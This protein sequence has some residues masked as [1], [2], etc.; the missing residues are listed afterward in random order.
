MKKIL[1]LT[2][3]LATLFSITVVMPSIQVAHGFSQAFQLVPEA[4]QGISS[5][6]LQVGDRVEGSFSLSNLGPYRDLLHNGQLASYWIN[7]WFLDPEGNVIMNFTH[8]SGDSFNYTALNWGTYEIWAFC[9]GN[10]FF[11]NPKNPEMTLN[12]EI[13]KA[14]MPEPANPDMMAWWKLDEGNGT[15]VYDSSLHNRQGTIHG[16]NWTN[17][18]GKYFLNFNGESDYVSLPSLNL[19][20]LDALTVSAWINSD[21]TKAGFIIYSGNLGEFKLGNGDLSVDGQISAQ[22]SNYANFSVKLSDNKWYT[23]SSSFPMKPNTWH[24][25]VGVW[26]KGDALKVYVDGVLAGKNDNIAPS[27]LYAADT[28]LPG[29]FPS[30][31]GIYSQANWDKQGFF[32]GQMSNVMVYNKALNSQE[33]EN[34]TTQIAGSLSIPKPSHPATEPFPIAFSIGIVVAIIIVLSGITIYLLKRK[35]E[36]KLNS[37]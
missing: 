33:I 26:T 11:E 7:V 6:E 21:L 14:K 31:L 19:T 22:S 37:L 12:F 9:S 15:V 27:G 18:N 13:V 16:A 4:Y 23:I 34:L 24:H 1:K 3:I 5:F 36:K 8:T 17:V 32:K 30:S 20:S 2:L 29:S 35:N 25:I 28:T 10:A